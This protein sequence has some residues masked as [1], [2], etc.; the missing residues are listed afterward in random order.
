MKIAFCL[1]NYFPFGGLQRDF[2]RIALACQQRGHTIIVYTMEW[3]GEIPPGFQINLV[4]KKGLSNH[5]RALHFSNAVNNALKKSPC[6]RVIGFNKMQGL[7]L[8]YAA[9]SCFAAKAKS[10]HGRFYRCLPR[11]RAYQQLEHA[12]FN[13]SSTTQVLLISDAEKPHFIRFYKMPEQNFHVLKP[14]I[15]R[16]RKQPTN[17][18]EIRQRV[19]ENFNLADNNFMLLMVGSGFKTKGLDRTLRS[20]AA[21]PQHLLQNIKLFIIGDDKAKPFAQLAQ[22][23]NIQDQIQF[24]G[25]RHDVPD[26]LWS[27]DLLLHPA[28]YENTGTVLLE[29]LVAGLPVLTTASCGYAH[30]VDT[31]Q[32]GTVIQNP[33]QQDLFNEALASALESIDLRIQWQNNALKFAESADIYQMTDQAIHLIEQAGLHA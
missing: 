12:V 30:Y 32:A 5:A 19:R 17:Y 8:Y 9:D 31:A 6:D 25:G 28:Y 7:D 22:Q 3:E 11:Y 2:L 26:F 13:S 27:A 4:K 24:L 15:S 20:I 33:Y 29:A 18:L 16:D 21:L 14:G 23:L 1:F 10:K